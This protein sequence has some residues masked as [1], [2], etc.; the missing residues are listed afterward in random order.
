MS[1]CPFS[2]G[3]AV[4]LRTGSAWD[5]VLSANAVGVVLGIISEECY[6]VAF[7]TGDGRPPL[8]GE[9]LGSELFAAQG[10]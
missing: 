8:V 2:I 10:S 3:Q 5:R 6:R 7:P 9:F 1:E 4:R